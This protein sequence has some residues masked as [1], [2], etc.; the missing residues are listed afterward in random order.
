[1]SNYR[2]LHQ[3]SLKANKPDL[4]RDLS[5]SGELEAHLD[6]VAESANSLYT[7]IVRQLAE[8]NPYNP[9]EWENSRAAWEGWLERT[10]QEL[11]LSD[12]VLVPDAE[13]EAAMRDGYL[14]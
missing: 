6:E 1:M 14:D 8:K 5:R 11:V 4:Y 10:A 3:D 9:V 2:Q 12:R 7:T 13:T